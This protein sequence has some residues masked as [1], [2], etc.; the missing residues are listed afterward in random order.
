MP[1]GG[2]NDV[3]EGYSSGVALV[4]VFNLIVGTGALAM[5]KAIESAG[6]L[7]GL[8]MI[9]FIAFMSLVTATMTIEA[10][11]CANAFSKWTLRQKQSKKQDKEV[12]DSSNIEEI[13]GDDPVEGVRNNPSR[14]SLQ[15][16][17]GGM[18][19]TDSPAYNG[20]R[21]NE[22]S[23]D[24]EQHP[25]IEKTSRDDEHDFYEIKQRIELG[26]MASMFFGKC[27]VGCFY[28]FIIVYLYGDLAIYGAAV[29]KSLRD[30]ICD[31]NPNN[32]TLNIT[33]LTLA[34]SDHC[35]ADEPEGLTRFEMYQIMLTVFFVL[36][37]PFTFFNVQKTKWLQILT[38]AL[39]WLSFL[40]MI[41][42]A[43]GRIAK[44]K[45]AHPKL[46]DINGIPNLFGACI[47]SF[48]CHHS[49]PSLV[50]P[51]KNKDKVTLLIIIDFALILGFYSLMCMTAVYAFEELEDLYTLNFAPHAINDVELNGGWIWIK[52]VIALF[53]VVTI[54]S[55]FP[56]IAITLRNNLKTLCKPK[57]RP[58]HK[59]VDRVLF[60]F[61]TV[62][63]PIVAVYFTNDV[64][65]LVGITGAF[66]GAG[67]Q[68]LLPAFLVWKARKH[69]DGIF[70]PTVKN[71]YSS[72]F[73]GTCWIW[74]TVSWC[75]LALIFVT[76]NLIEKHIPK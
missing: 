64:S 22:G 53:P 2:L 19:P 24:D 8:L 26:E 66:A 33:N 46:A 34:E 49:L 32:K 56:I 43:V 7:V 51:V 48:M 42:I 23:T 74:L 60:P 45:V 13:G 41:G 36:M 57:G 50:S 44:G 5:P 9:I 3:G 54:S 15:S 14:T 70:G 27:G 31:Y 62:V 72:P 67:I 73:K 58:Y 16:G 25:L 75:F 39:R 71:K 1:G 68:Y 11:A 21:N 40:M 55:S 10:M 37:L 30:V 17:R 76:W 47:Y 38:S 18:N 28:F 61:V 29:P 20:N 59:C 35:F 12:A 52:Y 6:W 65:T 4:Y 69:L 63:P